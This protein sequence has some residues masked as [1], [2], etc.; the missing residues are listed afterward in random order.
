[1]RQPSLYIPH[2]GGPCFFMDDPR[3]TWTGMETFLR[4]L[5][6]LLPERPTAILIVSGHWETDGFAFTAAARPDLLFD[7]HGFPPHTYHL[8]YPA[9]LRWR[10]RRRMCWQRPACLPASM[11][12]ADWIMACSCRS[13]SPSPMPISR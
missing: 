11:P 9:I 2:G 7:Y 5:P 10:R 1:M 13:R 12:R 4:D 8:T 3:G 6:K